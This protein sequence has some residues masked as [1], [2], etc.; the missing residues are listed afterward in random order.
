MPFYIQAARIETESA[1][2]HTE[3]WVRN[4]CEIQSKLRDAEL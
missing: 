2:M 3:S 4:T 1:F